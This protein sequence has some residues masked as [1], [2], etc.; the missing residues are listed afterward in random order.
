MNA[1]Q[2]ARTYAVMAVAAGIAAAVGWQAASEPVWALSMVLVAGVVLWLLLTPLA[3]ELAPYTIGVLL[4]LAS[5]SSMVP[6]TAVSVIVRVFGIGLLCAASLQWVKPGLYVRFNLHQKASEL[7]LWLPSVVG[8]LLLFLVLAAGFHGQWSNFVLYGIGLVIVVGAV[9][10]TAVTVPSAIVT[11]A[12]I[13]A[14]GV[15]IAGSLVF[16][17]VVPGEGIFAGRLRGLT[18]NANTLGFY[19]FLLG[20]LAL[21]VVRHVGV[22]ILLFSI[23]IAVVLW[24]SSRASALALVI[25]VLTVLLSRRSSTTA[26]LLASLIGTGVL[27]MIAWPQS[28]SIL[29]GVTRVND[30]RAGSFDVAVASFRSSPWIG[31]GMGNEQFEIASSPMRALGTAGIGGLIAVF[32]MWLAF[33]GYSTRFGFEA[34]GFTLAAIVHSLFEGWLLSPVGPQLLIFIVAWWALLH[35]E[36]RSSIV[37]PS[38]LRDTRTKQQ[39]DCPRFG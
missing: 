26:L 2:G 12:V 37:R 34:A 9:V 6:S 14:L 27:V 30:S 38:A 21:V 36:P 28:L 19:A 22:K 10:S 18:P 5:S 13:F 3:R 8:S 4:V 35:R 33:F 17:I 25:V 23:S 31:V 15:M 11:K 24:S 16:G 7:R 29:D 32:V 39:R 20:A 1:P